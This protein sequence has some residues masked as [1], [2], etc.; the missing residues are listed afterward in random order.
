V[1]KKQHFSYNVSLT[2][3][4]YIQN[5]LV[6]LSNADLDLGKESFYANAGSPGLNSTPFVRVASGAKIGTFWGPTY[7]GVNDNG[8]WKFIDRNKD[9]KITFEDESAIGNGLPKM[10]LGFGN[11]FTIGKLDL[12]LFFRG[13][14]G[15]DIVNSYRIFY[16]TLNTL[17]WNRIKADGFFNPK[18]TDGAKFSSYQVE[19]GT[20]FKLDNATVGYT[21]NLSLAAALP[22]CGFTWQV[23]TCLC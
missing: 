17:T 10:E 9:G 6:S 23:K 14:F 5:K 22:S 4:Y 3:T 8:T 16:E 21:F 20:Y 18:L 15:H 19:K 11:S 1:I 2:P 13:V 12:N 7:D